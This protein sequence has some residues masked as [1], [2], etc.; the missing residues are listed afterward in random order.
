M[1]GG[2]DDLFPMTR[3]GAPAPRID[4][5]DRATTLTLSLYDRLIMIT[6]TI[7]MFGASLD[8]KHPGSTLMIHSPG[9]L[10]MHAPRVP[11]SQ[12]VLTY[13]WDRP[14]A[15][16]YQPQH[17]TYNYRDYPRFNAYAN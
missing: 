12:E 15:V 9:L 3:I 6:H 4:I 2:I 5:Q 8:D 7:P 11:C 17:S 14:S 13:G 1:M 16:D 10:L